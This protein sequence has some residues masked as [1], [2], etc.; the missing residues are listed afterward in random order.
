VSTEEI[1]CT[2]H[3]LAGDSNGGPHT[4][5]ALGL[6]REPETL[7]DEEITEWRTAVSTMYERAFSKP[8]ESIIVWIEDAA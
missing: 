8:P 1:V 5:A 4:E 6:D 7:T 3:V 2:V